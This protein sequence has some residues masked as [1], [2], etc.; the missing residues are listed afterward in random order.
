MWQYLLTLFMNIQRNTIARTERPT[1]VVSLGAN[2]ESDS[3]SP[4][5]NLLRAME[6]LRDL[7][8]GDYKASSIYRTSAV[9]CP[10]GT[11]DFL[12]AVVVFHPA[13][14]FDAGAL[15]AELHA[16]ESEFGR[17]RTGIA[18]ESRT[19]DLDLIA[20]GDQCSEQPGLL[21]PHPRAHLRRFVLEPLA[22]LRPDLVLPG[23]SESVTALL[24][25]LDGA[26]SC[27]R[28]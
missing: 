20:Y 3:A 12:N 16:I 8:Q 18:N 19:M 13:T 17:I 24:A 7:S 22:E 14:A 4:A 10:P 9:D 26:E 2:L 25:G 5:E 21:L 1:V 27:Q 11:P 23:Q 6:R 15:L 28:L